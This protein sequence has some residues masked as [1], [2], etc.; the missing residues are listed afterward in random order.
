MIIDPSMPGY[1]GATVVIA[2]AP[3]KLPYATVVNTC[4]F[5]CPCLSCAKR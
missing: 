2:A 5:P 3:T 4:I 1:Q